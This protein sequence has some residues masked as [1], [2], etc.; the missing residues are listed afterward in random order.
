[1]GNYLSSQF[2]DPKVTN[3]DT[4]KTLAADEF[5]KVA[6]GAQMGESDRVAMQKLF[7]SSSS[8]QQLTQ[9]I[10]KAQQLMGGKVQGLNQAYQQLYP[11]HDVGERVSLETNQ[12]LQGMGIKFGQG[13]AG[14]GGQSTSLQTLAPADAAKLPAGTH[15][16]GQDGIERVAHGLGA[17]QNGAPGPV[18]NL[19]NLHTNG[20]Q[21]IGWNGSAWVDT[22]TGQAVQ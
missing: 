3:F 20:K 10:Q 22:K 6:A 19:S 16:L 5:A 1:V 21:T 2:G 15:F 17:T 7:S 4:V 9:A 11:G 8:P 12:V 13:G 18:A 14:Q